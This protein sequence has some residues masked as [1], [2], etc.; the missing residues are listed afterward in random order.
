VRKKLKLPLIIGWLQ[1]YKEIISSIGV[2]FAIIGT[3][4]SFFIGIKALNRSNE[5]FFENLRY[6]DQL[7]VK[8]SLLSAR[9]FNEN[10]SLQTRKNVQDS[11]YLAKQ[12]ALIENQNFL[13]IDPILELEPKFN[14][15]LE[16]NQY[17]FKIKNTGSSDVK[18]INLLFNY[19]IITIDSKNQIQAHLPYSHT[20]PEEIVDALSM[21]KSAN[22]CINYDLTWDN[23]VNELKKEKIYISTFKFIKIEIFFQ[24]AIDFRSY[25]FCK[26]YLT[27]SSKALME[28]NNL[29][30]TE[31]IPIKSINQLLEIN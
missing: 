21:R 24:R 22:F 16:N 12:L 15:P 28:T 14:V 6:Q 31:M 13:N 18:H 4:V 25:S 2:I 7:R 5:Q 8:D 20:A 26:L 9:Q 19:Y 30:N 27:T 17:N 3:I 29:P 23:T 11:L 1:E 10:I